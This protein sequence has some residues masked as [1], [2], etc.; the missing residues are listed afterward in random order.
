MNGLPYSL[1]WYLLGIFTCSLIIIG[2][3]LLFPSSSPGDT[4]TAFFTLL[5]LLS[6]IAM[7]PVRY[8][9]R[10][11]MFLSTAIDIATAWILSPKYTIL[12]MIFGHILYVKTRN[13]WYKAIFNICLQIITIGL[14]SII[15]SYI[16]IPP[17]SQ[18]WSHIIL[19]II[20]A[21]LYTS[22]YMV[23]IGTAI[24]LS[25]P[26]DYSL[27]SWRQNVISTFTYIDLTLFFCGVVLGILWFIGPQNFM[28]GLT[29]LATMYWSLRSDADLRKATTQQQQL[30]D[31]LA[32]ML[33]IRDAAQQLKLLLRQLW[34]MFTIEYAGIVL[35]PRGKDDEGLVVI[36]PEVEAIRNLCAQTDA[37]HSLESDPRIRQ[38][39]QEPACKP[40]CKLPTYY[41]P[42]IVSDEVVGAML[43]GLRHNQ[44]VPQDFRL[45]TTYATQ[46][47]LVVVQARLIDHLRSSQE[48]LVRAERL[49]AIGKLAAN[50]AHEFNNV[51]AII[52]TTAE[53]AVARRRRDV[54]TRAL[55]RISEAAKR[56][57]SITRGLLTFTRHFEP[58]RERML[59]QDA[60]EPILAMLATRFR[61]NQITVVRELEP[62]LAVVGDV[63]LLAQAVLNIVTNALDAMPNGG[64]LTLR[65]WHEEQTIHLQI[66]DDG[67]G[68]TA[69][70]RKRLFE[71][72]TTSKPLIAQTIG[73]SGLGLAITFGIVTSHDGTLTIESEPGAGTTILI[74]LPAVEGEWEPP[75][76]MP[77]KRL[78]GP[79]RI[80]IVDDEPMIAAGLADILSM[81]G[82]EV[83]WFEEP[84]AAVAELDHFVPEVLIADLQM[85]EISGKQLLK[86]AKE[87]LPNIR[88]V[89]IT[90][91]TQ[92]PD[93]DPPE[94]GVDLIA[95]P[96]TATDIY[97][98]LGRYDPVKLEDRGAGKATRK[99]DEH[100][101]LRDDLRHE[102][103][104][105]VISL[106]NTFCMLQS[107]QLADPATI[108]RMA[109]LLQ[110]TICKATIF[111]RSQYML[112]LLDSKGE[113]RTINAYQS[114]LRKRLEEARTWTSDGLSKPSHV[115]VH[116][117]CPPDLEII[118][119]P[120]S[121]LLALLS[122]T[123]NAIASIK[124]AAVPEGA[125][126]ISARQAGASIVLSVEDNGEGFDEDVLEDLTR[127]IDDG[128]GEQFLGTLE[129]RYGVG[130]GI[131]VTVHMAKVHRGT[132]EYG[133]HADRRGAWV[134]WTLP[135]TTA[136]D[137]VAGEGRAALAAS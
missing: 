33:S 16:K 5:G 132:V 55:Q 137:V 44:L 45:L 128:Y 3:V 54:Q 17:I 22:T 74:T 84:A 121:L 81:D 34:H 30:Q 48:Q 99:S 71:P 72:F 117:E 91:Q 88:Q 24:T 65:A 82:H 10:V 108:Q 122:A 97:A 40:F 56:G 103:I 42:L 130:I 123:Q 14:P 75:T 73:G 60:I 104:N 110:P 41:I 135:A 87:R 58:K 80:M 105:H 77:P 129:P 1:R 2:F 35:F 26:S 107:A 124:R 25:D 111:L 62:P 93:A 64:T 126:T 133:N 29:L 37:L 8:S 114:S 66:Q 113:P 11:V 79:Q 118:A 89:L 51:L 125:I 43:L 12:V 4:P 63:G 120:T 78:E 61:D 96:F 9:G 67:P 28:L 134:R 59:L 18:S 102:L 116:V 36:T 69:S 95:K 53:T 13:T 46:A 27:K 7:W 115:R 52:C 70:V 32:S 131:P 76:P 90:G 94:P 39:D 38:I 31:A 6:L 83:M 92:R 50:L 49:A 127:Y 15:F 47:A 136:Q 20:T 100:P 112:G 21:A 19:I 23:L 68:L 85:P 57:G 106:E 86:I 119:D 109:P 101:A 98:L